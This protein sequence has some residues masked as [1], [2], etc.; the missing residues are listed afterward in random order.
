MS[1]PASLEQ[2]RAVKE[3]VARRLAGAGEVVGVGLTKARGGYAVK[4]NLKEPPRGPV[5]DEVDG[6]PLLIDVVGVVRK[7]NG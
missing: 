3:E 1:K 5:P 4:V 7:R 6:V 2:A